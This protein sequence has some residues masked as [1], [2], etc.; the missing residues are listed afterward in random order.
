MPL[1]F[2]VYRRVPAGGCRKVRIE[3]HDLIERIGQEAMS[4]LISTMEEG[5]ST[6]R[7]NGVSAEVWDSVALES[8]T[9]N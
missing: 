7:V 5:F 3:P 9:T 8:Y 4:A 1:V 6:I 2:S